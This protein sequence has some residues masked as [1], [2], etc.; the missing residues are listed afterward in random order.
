MPAVLAL[1]AFW[2]AVAA[3]TGA[4]AAIYGADKSSS[5]ST[6]AANTQAAAAEQA[7]QLQKQAS[8]ATLAFEQQQAAQTRADTIA[9]QNANFGQWTYRQN[10][11]RPYQGTGLQAENTLAQMLGLPASST[12]LPDLPSAPTYT[13]V[14]PTSSSN[15]SPTTSSPTS[16]ASS[17][18]SSSS[19]PSSSSLSNPSSW[20]SMVNNPSQL[21]AWVKSVA[22]KMSDSLVNYYVGKIQGQPGANASEQ[23]GSANYWAQ[24]IASDPTLTGGSSTSNGSSSSTNASVQT[25]PI[26]APTPA[27]TGYTMPFLT[28]T[29]GS[30]ATGAA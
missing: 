25:S 14:N 24:K 1:P 28:N 7:A 23:A 8:D 27:G 17:S 12:T 6:Q 10:S 19:V 22:P 4:G 18:S 2:G 3:G 29:I 30:Y 5:A 11:I 13:T 16:S 15:T 9:S 20:M 26:T 21:T